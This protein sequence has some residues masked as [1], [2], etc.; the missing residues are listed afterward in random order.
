MLGK[1]IFVKGEVTASADLTIE[2]RIVGPVL[3]DGYTVVIAPT[4]EVTG[5]IRSRD[6][7]VFGQ[8]AGQ[9]VATESVCLRPGA[10][11]SGPILTPKFILDPGAI[12]NG[13]VE[14][15]HLDAALR[16]ARFREQ[17]RERESG[18]RRNACAHRRNDVLQSRTAPSRRCAARAAAAGSC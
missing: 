16:V 1:T 8:S 4:A 17:R 6:I 7:T 10:I 12:F 13:R 5:D 9:L 2:G 3:C 11:V 14:P 18:T 15:Q